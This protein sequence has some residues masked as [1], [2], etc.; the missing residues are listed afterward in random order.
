MRD[1][2][3]GWKIAKVTEPKEKD[4]L[5]NSGFLFDVFSALSGVKK[6]ERECVPPT[7]VSGSI[8]A[9]HIS[10]EI[11]SCKIHSVLVTAAANASAGWHHR[12]ASLAPML[13]DDKPPLSPIGGTRCNNRDIRLFVLRSRLHI[14]ATVSLYFCSKSSSVL[15]Q[16][17]DTLNV[18]WIDQENLRLPN[19]Y[20]L[21]D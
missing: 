19:F 3:V 5:D 1:S 12:I 11:F 15:F 13:P 18:C 4:L 6:R 21:V 7:K 8:P 14:S 17:W 10:P 9:Q 16:S 2:A 20:H